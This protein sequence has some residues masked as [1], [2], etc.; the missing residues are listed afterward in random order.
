MQAWLENALGAVILTAFSLGWV[1]WLW[2]FNVEDSKVLH[3]VGFGS[4]YGKLGGGNGPQSR[5]PA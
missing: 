4:P 1:D 5:D 2:I 3:L